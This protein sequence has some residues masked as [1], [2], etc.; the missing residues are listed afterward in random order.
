MSKNSIYRLNNAAGYWWRNIL[1]LDSSHTDVWLRTL[2]ITFW[3]FGFSNFLF[4]TSRLFSWNQG[5]PTSGPRTGP[6]PECGV[7]QYL[8]LVL[9]RTQVRVPVLDT[10][11]GLVHVWYH[12]RYCSREHPNHKKWHGGVLTLMSTSRG[13]P[14][15]RWS[16][17]LFGSSVFLC[18]NQFIHPWYKQ[19]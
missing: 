7:H 6:V 11:W 13:W 9:V 3:R 12:V 17:H 18:R 1:T 2:R 15:V 5:S 4:L 14:R 10:S 16:V 8:N 19:N